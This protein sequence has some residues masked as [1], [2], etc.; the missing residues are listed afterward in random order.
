MARGVFI[1][2]EGIDGSG[3]STHVKLLCDELRRQG[4]RV[5]Q[6]EEPSRG[7][8]GRFIRDAV[9]QG[10]RRGWVEV[11]ALLFAADRF[12]HTKGVIEPALEKGL[13]AVSDRYV[14]SSLAYQGAEGLSL[15]WIRELN[16]FALKPDLVLLLDITPKAGLARM[17]RRR[18]TVFEEHDPLERV[19]S[20]YLQLAEQGELVKVNADGPVEKVQHGIFALVQTLLKAERA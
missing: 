2:F 8:I 6:T 11:E 7:R 16:R 4:H 5:L 15:D 20:I 12:E 13:I 18:K 17:N 10:S 3:K 19:R 1:V 9:E 14:H